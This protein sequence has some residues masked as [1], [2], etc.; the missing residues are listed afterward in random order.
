MLVPVYA[1]MGPLFVTLYSHEVGLS[2]RMTLCYNFRPG[3]DL[4]SGLLSSKKKAAS[5]LLL[6]GPN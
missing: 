3:D 1:L 6:E 2:G 4:F 5:N